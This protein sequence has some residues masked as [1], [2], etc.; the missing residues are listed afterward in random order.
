MDD[1]PGE[2][3]IIVDDED[4]GVRLSPR[5]A[6]M[7]FGDG[8]SWAAALIAVGSMIVSIRYARE[9]AGHQAEITRL[10][11]EQHRLEL[12]AWTDQYFNVVRAWEDRVCGTISVSCHRYSLEHSYHLVIP[13]NLASLSPPPQ[14]RP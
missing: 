2:A 10:T 4:H 1:V 6:Q 14:P 11:K 8:A 13:A 3:V 7:N 12:R 5:R 9:A